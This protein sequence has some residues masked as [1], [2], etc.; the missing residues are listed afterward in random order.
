MDD[1]PGRLRAERKADGVALPS[2]RTLAANFGLSPLTVH[3]ALRVLQG[4]GRVH[5]VPRK[6]FFWGKEPVAVGRL[7]RRTDRLAE[8]RDKLVSDLR[9]GV[10]HPHRELPS[11]LALSQIYGIAPGRIGALL[12]ELAASGT[13][14]RR[15]RGFALP[16]P[17]RRADE[18]TVLVVSRCDA[19]GTLLLDTE[20]QTDF[21]KSVHREGRERALRIVVL[22][23]CQ[24]Q[25]TGV[26]LNQDGLEVEPGS[27]PGILLGCLV[28]TW[29]VRDPR[30]LLGELG[31][32]QVPI[33]VWW[34][35]PPGDFPRPGS[36][37]APVL[38][39]NLSFGPSSGVV[40]GRHLR[41]SHLRTR[42]PGSVAFV[43]PFHGGDWS[44]ARLEGLREGLRGTDIEI[45][46]F[47]DEAHASAWEH[48]QAEGGVAAGERRIREILSCFLDRLDPERYP[49][50]VAVNDHTAVL[51]LD[52][53]R[54]RGRR[55][56]YLVSFDN[57]SI[58]DAHQIDSFEFHTEGMVRQMLYHLL[59]PKA[60]LFRN[61]G[62]HEMVGRLVLRT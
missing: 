50:W 58:S 54:E 59:H 40:V 2:I 31:R 1:L 22:G 24:D 52:L 39:F 53:L 18:G 42:E 49:T 33:S 28:S 27:V 57:S 61:G 43:S 15:G 48:H 5:S 10:F 21:I 56:P 41:T 8:T 3:R 60:H 17:P 7:P 35:H 36:W 30:V 37:K 26:F 45:V 34:E 51:L 9:S 32:L 4:E 19:S 6:G 16:T 38:G 14:L 62:L 47:V 55:R 23:W 12:D 11:R 25:G 20:R 44:R 46:P 29:L 13:L